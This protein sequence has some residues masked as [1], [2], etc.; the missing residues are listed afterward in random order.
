[1][2][3]SILGLAIALAA[4]QALACGKWR[5]DIKTGTDPQ[6]AQI[7][8]NNID[9]VAITDL[10]SLPRPTY[11]PQNSRIAPTEMQVYNINA[12]IV[13]IRHEDDG[14][15]HLLAQ[16]SGGNTMITEIPDP[17]CVGSSSPFIPLIEAARSYVTQNWNGSTRVNIPASITGVAF[18]DF[19]HAGG[20]APNAIELHPVL[21][22]TFLN[23]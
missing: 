7:N 5:W 23:Q 4:T 18:F 6:A 9:H 15:Y 1:M 17:Q 16:D 19:P 11:Y 12:T 3:S 20:A 21:K 13:E 2:K 10:I 8:V 14:D 22:I